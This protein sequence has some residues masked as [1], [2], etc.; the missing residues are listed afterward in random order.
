MAEG[1]YSGARA[2][3]PERD[4]EVGGEHSPV[5]APLAVLVTTALLTL[6]QLYAAIP[7]ASV[8]GEDF[9]GGSATAALAT[10]WSL[11]YAAGF[12]VFGPVS[13]RY[14]RKTILVPGMAAL[15]VATASVSMAPSIG[16]LAALRAV[17]GFAAATFT[18]V[19]LAWASQGLPPRWR[20]TAIGAMSTAFM[21]A[22]IL[23]Q[24]YA[25][26]LAL[27]V[28]WRPVFWVAAV[29]FALAA[30]GLA[31]VLREPARAG[32]GDRLGRRF[33]QLARF[34]TRRE[35]A[36]PAVAAFTLLLTFVA[37]YAALG[38]WLQTQ[39]GLDSTAVLLVRLAGLPAM[40]LAPLA[41]ALGARFGL[42]RISVAGYTLAALGLGLIALTAGTLWAL[43]IASMVFVAGVATAIPNMISLFGARAG[44]ARAAGISLN[45]FLLFTGA[46]LGQ[47]L[48]DLI[49]G[50][51][52]LVMALATVMIASAI[53]VALS[54]LSPGQHASPQT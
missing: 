13:D 14:G 1:Y 26:A 48:P 32:S 35:F 46:S 25:Q 10:T 50:F 44:E 36:L 23:G 40:L 11:A 51:I 12:L 24:V 18:P 9:G 6:M 22:G 33:G 2:R 5:A 43:V 3:D 17:Q 19:A 21:V 34:L 54:A 49:P 38:P 4:P 20:T 30:I 52:A 47:L 15:A 39:F 28:G 45:G 8:V 29:A 27:A 53:L 31:T 41:G 16:V 37:T 7:L 42:A